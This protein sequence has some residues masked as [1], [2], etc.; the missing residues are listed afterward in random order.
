MIKRALPGA[1]ALLALLAALPAAQAADIGVV[2]LFPGKA[3]LVVDGGAPRTYEVGSTVALGVRLLAADQ[4]GATLESRGRREVIA[5][6]SHVN[7]Q[8]PSAQAGT[9][10]QADERGHFFAQGMI[11]GN[12]VRMLVDTGA[13]LIALPAADAQRMGIDYR[14]GGRGTVSTANGVVPVYRVRLDTVRIGDLELSQVDAL[15]QEQGLPIALLGMSFLNRTEMRRSGEQM[16][17]QRRY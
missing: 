1:A 13:S 16:T 8:A 2:G 9:V 11:N 7:R 15:V 12:P 14:H 17:L 3:V 4:S 5:L 6:G 10:L